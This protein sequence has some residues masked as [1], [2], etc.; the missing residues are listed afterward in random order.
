MRKLPLFFIAILL[1]GIAFSQTAPKKLKLGN[2]A[3]DHFMFQIGSN[4]WSGAAD[5]VKKYIKTINRSANV[6]LMIDKPFRSNPRF[7][8]AIGAGIGTSN[9][10]F[11]NMEVKIDAF[12][13]KLPFVRTDTG[14]HFK[15]YKLSMAYLEAPVELRFMSRP[16]TPNKSIKGAIGIKIGTL[17]NVHTKGKTLENSAGT[18]LNGFTTKIST[19]SYFNTTRLA[20]TARAGYGIFTLFG[21]Y[22][23]TGV[24]K[25][26]VAPDTRLIQVGLSISGL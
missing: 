25:D 5:S 23:I 21:S 9:I 6:Y 3:A 1:S 11:D 17:L 12:K 19:R 4:F 13:P 22:N 16:E 7:S 26:G 10:F 15:K 8:A 18:K 20:L 14:N 24:F 2:R